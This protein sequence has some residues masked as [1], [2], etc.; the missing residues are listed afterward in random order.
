MSS[1]HTI[2][3]PVTP[4]PQIMMGMRGLAHSLMVILHLLPASCSWAPCC[5]WPSLVKQGYPT[6][7]STLVRGL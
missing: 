2:K 5:Y 6:S 4:R 7:S 3:A 1:Q